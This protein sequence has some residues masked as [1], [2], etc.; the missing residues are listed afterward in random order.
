MMG[1]NAA[2]HYIYERATGVVIFHGEAWDGHE[3]TIEL[4]Q[5]MS[6]KNFHYNSSL[7][8]I[9]LSKALTLPLTN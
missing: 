9:S 5:L 7:T 8:L 4:L 1:V 2:M 3:R 6:E